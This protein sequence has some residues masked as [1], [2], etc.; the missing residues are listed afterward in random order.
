MKTNKIKLLACLGF[1]TL[2]IPCF[3]Q[4]TMIWQRLNY[5]IA[6]FGITA[7]AG[8]VTNQS[9]S[10]LETG[11]N[12]AY[13]FG[14]SPGWGFA[15]SFTV[16]SDRT[17]N[18]IQLRLGGGGN[19]TGQGQ[20]SLSVYQF[21]QQTDT[22]GSLLGVVGAD[23][24]NYQYDIFNVPVSSFDFSSLNIPL[25]AS[26][27]YAWVLTPASPSWS[28]SITIQAAV[29]SLYPG[30]FAYALNPTP[31]PATPLLL[32]LG[33]ATLVACRSHKKTARRVN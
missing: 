16:P 4:G 11:Y 13:G 29:A 1:T 25:Y 10:A 22:P 8:G 2:V 19:P 30:G 7:V 28:G 23:A 31:E 26:A 5:G 20:F 32:V 12:G 33:A 24:A 27:A 17:L 6:E 9:P 21:N 3:G 18:S 14:V 15:Q